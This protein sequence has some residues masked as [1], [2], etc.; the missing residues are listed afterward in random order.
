M[1]FSFGLTLCL[2]PFLIRTSVTVDYGPS[3]TSFCFITSAMTLFPNTATFW[4]T[5]GLELQQIFFK[6][7]QSKPVTEQNLFEQISH[8]DARSGGVSLLVQ[9]HLV[10]TMDQWLTCV[11]TLP[12]F[13]TRGSFWLFRFYSFC[14]YWLC[15]KIGGL[16]IACV[17]DFRPLVMNNQSNPDSTWHYWKILD[18]ILV[19][20]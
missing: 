3:V 4:D 14:V 7:K 17:L 18:F 2:F 15:V 13:W 12:F 5:G 16:G 6:G 1:A 11:W 20:Q 9:L 8:S 19:K 10:I